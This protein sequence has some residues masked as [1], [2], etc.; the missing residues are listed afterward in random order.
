MRKAIQVFSARLSQ[1]EQFIRA[2]GLEPPVLDA[3]DA[4]MIERL[5]DTL[6]QPGTSP[7]G[8]LPS[9]VPELNAVAEKDDLLTEAISLHAPACH[10]SQK[11]AP[12]PDVEQGHVS[13]PGPPGFMFDMAQLTDDNQ[14]PLP[15][16]GVGDFFA[17][18]V[19]VDQLAALQDGNL[20]FPEWTTD[21]TGLNAMPLGMTYGWADLQIP[22]PDVN[23]SGTDN[24]LD[25]H[26]SPYTSSGSDSDAHLSPED[27]GSDG[28]ISE[29]SGRMGSL[30]V[31]DD[32]ELRYFGATSNMILRDDIAHFDEWAE[33]NIVRHRAQMLLDSAGLGQTVDA[34]L[35]DHLTNLYFTWQDPTFHVVDREL[36]RQSR[37]THGV[38]P[39]HSS[40]LS[41]TL[42]N[43]M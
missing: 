27:E 3:N 28:V 7:K 13:L 30:Q 41:E 32:G 20:A 42:I 4:A 14:L 9:E 18:Y 36:Y 33:P 6:Q 31:S 26:T 22:Y 43:A 34:A 2:N 16:T 15:T 10:G 21:F 11:K 37:A 24:S 29:I 38:H 8:Q 17:D 1:L 35:E 19:D 12:Q 39:G 23:M 5:I 25:L 40:Y